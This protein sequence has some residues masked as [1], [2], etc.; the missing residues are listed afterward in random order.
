MLQTMTYFLIKLYTK[1]IDV[2][3]KYIILFIACKI[4]YVLDI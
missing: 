3:V 2:N 1:I 4:F